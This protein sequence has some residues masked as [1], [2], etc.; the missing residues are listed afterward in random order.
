MPKVGLLRLAIVAG[1]RRYAVMESRP[2]A[3][4]APT[5][6]SSVRPATSSAEELSRV[7]T[8][9]PWRRGSGLWKPK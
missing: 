3:H 4:N 9:S 7:A 1:A 2:A 6:A 5:S 8:P